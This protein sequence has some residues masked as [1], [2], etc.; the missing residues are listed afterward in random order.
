[1]GVGVGEDDFHTAAAHAPSHSRSHDVVVVPPTDLLDG[2]HVLVLVVDVGRCLPVVWS[3]SLLVVRVGIVIPIHAVA[4]VAAIF[5]GPHGVFARFVDVEHLS[6]V[7]RLIDVEHFPGAGGSSSL[8][9]VLVADGDELFHVL[10]RDALVATLIEENARVVAVV[11]DGVAHQFRPLAPVASSHVFLSIACWHG[12][13][14][15]HAVARLHILLARGDM[16]PSDEVPSRL[17]HEI[18]GVVR[19]PSRN[20]DSHCRPFVGGALGI[21]MHHD[22][23]VVEPYFPFCEFRLTESSPGAD[24]ILNTLFTF[25][26]E[27]GFHSV[28]VAVAPRPEVHVVEFLACLKG[29]GVAC[30]DGLL[31]A[32]EACNGLSVVVDDFHL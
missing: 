1:M 18:V 28:E 7:F 23:A 6:S 3:G 9:V 17:D 32:V 15:S 13:D 14:K 12:L 8:W 24:F 19:H 31:L 22:D 25:D 27:S 21:A 2:E 16:H 30:C 10:S 29:D 20:V 26:S 4:F 5:H 11:D